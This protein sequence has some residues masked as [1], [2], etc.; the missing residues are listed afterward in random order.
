MIL[1][2]ALEDASPGDTIIVAGF[3]NGSDA[4]LCHVTEEIEKVRDQKRGV[5][6][7]L[8]SKRDLSSYEMYLTFWGFISPEGGIRAEAIP[9]AALPLTWRDRREILG[10]CGTRCKKCG[11]PQY[12]AQ[13]VCVNPDCGAIDEME[14]YRFSDKKGT[15]FSFTGDLLAFTPIPPA[16]YAV[17]DFDGG[18]RFWFDVTDSDLESIEIGM[19]VEMSFRR[20]YVDEKGGIVGYF[21]KVVPIQE[22]QETQ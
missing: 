21:W 1:I 6:R 3:G 8:E 7:Y 18:G 5:K 15:I 9:Y 14:S 4:L 10:L 19:P 16:I 22:T 12:P 2:S 17:I 20:R 11:T 13:R